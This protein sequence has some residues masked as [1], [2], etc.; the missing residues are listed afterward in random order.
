M[1]PQKL[2]SEIQNAIDRGINLE[3][4]LIAT[5]VNTST[6]FNLLDDM[7]FSNRQQSELIQVIKEW[8]RG[9]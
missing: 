8:E 2:Q 9:K 3:K 4:L 1:S 5:G 6:F 7:L